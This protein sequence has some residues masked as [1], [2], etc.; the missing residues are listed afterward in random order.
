MWEFHDFFWD[1][2]WPES[3]HT[4]RHL[5]GEREERVVHRS[6]PRKGG[7]VLFGVSAEWKADQESAAEQKGSLGGRAGMMVVFVTHK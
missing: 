5:K 7:E 1:F 4:G 3:S 6:E 2:I